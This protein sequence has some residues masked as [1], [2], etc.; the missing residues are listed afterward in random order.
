MGLNGIDMVLICV[1][2]G[3]RR[4]IHGRKTRYITLNGNDTARILAL[5]AVESVAVNGGS[6]EGA[7]VVSLATETT[8]ELALAV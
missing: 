8:S 2:S 1:R 5:Q 7:K 4:Y 3:R 6:V